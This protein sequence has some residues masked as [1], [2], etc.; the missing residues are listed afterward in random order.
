M[1]YTAKDTARLHLAVLL[2]SAA[3]WVGMACAPG[4]ACHGPA[5]GFGDSLTGSFT[6]LAAAAPGWL[7]MLIGMMAPMALGGLYQVRISSFTK[8][9][10]R[11]SALFLAGYAGLWML[12]GIP[13]TAAALTATRLW[14]QSYAAATL[15]GLLALVWQA[16]PFKQRS[17][18]R[19]HAHRP[20][21]AFGMAAD[22]DALRMGRD[23]GVWCIA[24]CWALMLFPMLLPSGHF[25][26]M[27]AMAILMYSE[28]LAPPQS[29][30]WRMRG[31]QFALRALRLRIS[32]PP[33]GA[34][35]ARTPIPLP[36]R[37]F[38][39]GSLAK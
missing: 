38:A 20:L 12:A 34:P 10:W 31:F 32:A 8:R 24:S 23:H 25:P 9:R 18:N 35:L 15:V 3:G 26:A 16:S 17:L 22:W 2:T 1:I 33:S 28:R 5:G 14:P 11:S 30:A 6:A 19:C 13:I 39:T 27:A 29:P 4:H 37:V 36:S 7:L 21:S